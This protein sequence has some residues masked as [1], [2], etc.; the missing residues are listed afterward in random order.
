MLRKAFKVFLLTTVCLVPFTAFAADDSG[1]DLDAAP[2][3]QKAEA[4]Q[5]YDNEI[6]FGV[7]GVI[8]S[9]TGL[10]G[11]Y[12]GF[13]TN[14]A[15]LLGD[16]AFHGPSKWDSGDTGYYDFTGNDIVYQTGNHLSADFGD[17]DYTRKTGNNIA[18]NGSLNITMG[19]QGAWVIKG[20]ADSISYTGNIIDSLYTV[21]GDTA[22]LN[23]GLRNWGGAPANQSGAGSTTTYTVS[24]LS[25]YMDRFQTGTRRDILGGDGKYIYGDWTLAS[26]LKH[27]HKQGSM[28]ESFYGTYGGM[29][30]KMP[31]DYDTDRYDLSAVYSAPNIQSLFQY[32]FD[33]FKDNNAAIALPYPVSSASPA[34][35]RTALYSTPPSTS[36]HYFTAMGA[37]NPLPSTRINV[38]GRFG[39][40]M[41]DD[42]FP[43]NT[44]DPG[45]TS[46][47]L[48]GHLN[49]LLQGTN[50]N[51]LN[52][53]ATV[54][55][56]NMTVSSHLLTDLDAHIS[57]GFEGRNVSLN[58]YKVYYGGSS[59]DGNQSTAVY[60]VPQEWLKEKT[61]ADLSYR[62]LPKSDTKITLG[63]K[64]DFVDRSNA[65][66]GRSDTNT[67]SIAL[68]SKLGSDA[69]GKVSYEHTNRSA[70]L[71]FQTPWINSLKKA[72]SSSASGAFYQAPLTADSIKLRTDYSP[73]H[74]L[75]GGLFLRVAS[76]NY[77]YPSIAPGVN[78]VNSVEGIKHDHNISAG[79]DISYRPTE[80]VNT[81]LFYTYEQIF[82]DNVGNGACANSATGA[83][84]GSSGYFKNDYTSNVSTVGVG[85]EWQATPALK[86]GVNYNFSYGSVAFSQYNG[87]WVASPTA[88]YQNVAN[89]PDINSTMHSLQVN[90]GY[91]IMPNMELVT[92]YAFDMFRNN[93][94]NDL[95]SAVQSTTQGGNTISILTPGYSS[96]NYT[97]S[98]IMTSLKIKF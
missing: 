90:A 72:N 67:G 77:N 60:V 21:T 55:Q 7:R 42:T 29:A 20:Y 26:A 73:S 34:Y 3:E 37:Y 23:P 92:Q 71:N 40:E 33:N 51:S 94:W 59:A 41:Q 65:Q 96:P 89:Y 62:I 12:N 78:L 74:D 27:E 52:A 48:G 28:E 88:L 56:G 54:Y 16:F 36:A 61:A 1:F 91:E 85:S 84:L 76:D 13:T 31:I 66:V 93:D 98:T 4:P 70:T 44:G 83:C 80:D 95:S 25:R 30:F 58:Q 11:R 32:T 87:V 2:V 14:G 53:T 6:N 97:V 15:D 63:Y 5:Q 75:S 47:S 45:I 79:P 10:Y 43:A 8:G 82:Y 22:V 50:G 19:E 57:A 9:N 46:S 18:P 86:F 35:A 24:G 69:T 64:F 68:S 39:L 81:H 38:N 17:K 49:S